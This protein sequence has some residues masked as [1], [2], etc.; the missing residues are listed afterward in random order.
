[1]KPVLRNHCHQ[2]PPCLQRQF[3]GGKTYIWTHLSLETACLET[4]FSWQKGCFLKK[5]YVVVSF[6]PNPDI[7]IVPFSKWS[8]IS[9]FFVKILVWVPYSRTREALTMH[10]LPICSLYKSLRSSLVPTCM[11]CSCA[12]WRQRR[13]CNSLPSKQNFYSTSSWF[14]NWIEWFVLKDTL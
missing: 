3:S 5:P 7:E 6:D 8:Y 9:F 12:R 13:L 4:P 10:T 1:M 11:Q 14:L 2:R